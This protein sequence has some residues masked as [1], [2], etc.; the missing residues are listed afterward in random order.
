MDPTELSAIIV[1]GGRSSRMGWPKALLPF[2]PET[3]VE[4]MVRILGEICG[5]VVVA[6]A[7]DQP[8]ALPPLTAR[9]V[10]DR[11]GEHGPLEGLRVGLASLVGRSRCAFVTG[12]DTPLLLPAFVRR[13]VQLRGSHQASVPLV[14]GYFQPLSAVYH[15]DVVPAIDGLLERERRGLV[16]LLDRIDTRAIAA[17]ELTSVDPQLQ[18]LRNLNTPDDYLAALAEAGFEPSGEVLAAWHKR[19]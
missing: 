10:R 8:W 7:A 5:E 12:C 15:V 14:G 11:Q 3:L 2:G 13:V 6:A 4:R 18:S 17:D 16:D 9:I 1:C 19:V